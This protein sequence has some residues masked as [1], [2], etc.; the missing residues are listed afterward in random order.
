MSRTASHRKAMLANMAN[1]LIEHKRISTTV[2]K[3]KALRGFVEPLITKSKVDNTHSR[4]IV[5]RY[6]RDKNAVSE[7][8][9]EI[10]PKIAERPGGYTRIIK[11]GFRLGDSA[12]MCMLELVDYNEIYNPN[13]KQSGGKKRRRR[14]KKS[15]DAQDSTAQTG[16]EQNSSEDT[17]ETKAEVGEKKA[18]AAKPETSKADS[19]KKEEK[20]K[21]EPKAE[22]PSSKK[23]EGSDKEKKGE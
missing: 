15:A 4:R 13:E 19:E 6:L 1:S 16:Q 7:L 8:F 2:A 11:T 14:R 21:A 17:K 5:F 10:A 3:A 23:D 20:P 12:E 18:E 9:R 22:K